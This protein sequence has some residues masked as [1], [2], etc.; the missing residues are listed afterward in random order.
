MQGGPL[1]VALDPLF[2]HIRNGLSWDEQIELIANV[3]FQKRVLGYRYGFDKLDVLVRDDESGKDAAFHVLSRKVDALWKLAQTVSPAVPVTY[4]VEAIELLGY[5]GD[6]AL[7]PHVCI[8]FSFH[9][10]LVRV[11]LTLFVEY[12]TGFA[13]TLFVAQVDY[14]EGWSVIFSVGATAHFY[15]KIK[16][17]PKQTVTLKSGDVVRED[18]KRGFL[19]C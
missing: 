18:R 5:K 7:E 8:L 16:D 15:F 17:Q 10:V 9:H 4:E 14:V 19:C 1:A 11:G 6:S 3:T 12:L 13:R 2:I